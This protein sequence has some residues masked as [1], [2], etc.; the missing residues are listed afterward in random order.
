[1]KELQVITLPLL[2]AQKGPTSS[3]AE[4]IQWTTILI[5]L[6]LVMGVIILFVRQRSLRKRDDDNSKAI[7][8]LHELRRMKRK[9]E[10]T[11]EEFE[12]LKD[13]VN[14]QT[15]KTGPFARS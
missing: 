5:L 2:L 3:P 7:Y 9:G 1:M 15:R 12:K 13:I 4:I 11:E 10:I 6:V 14:T 8:S